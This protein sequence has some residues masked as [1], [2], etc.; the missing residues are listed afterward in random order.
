MPVNNRSMDKSSPSILRLASWNLHRCIGNDGV[1]SVQRCAAVLQ[2]INADLMVLQEVESHPGREYDALEA[3]ARATA[4]QAIAGMTMKHEDSDYGNAILTRLPHKAIRRHDISVNRR[5]PRGALDID[6]DIDDI[7]V[8]VVATH[9]GLRTRERHQQV[10]HL[11][12]IINAVDRDITILAGDFNEWRFWGRSLHGL[13]RH[14][15]TVPYHRSWPSRFPLFALDRVWVSPCSRLCSLKTHR[16]ALAR[17]TS[18]HLPLV[19]EIQLP[20]NKR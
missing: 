2:E 20:A 4:S 10:Q 15:E 1:Q 11:L 3:L 9:L 12:S 5:E 6:M 13:I 18:D 8:Q 7:Q 17:Q 16:S 14:F 19:A